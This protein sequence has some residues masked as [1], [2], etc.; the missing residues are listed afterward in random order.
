MET[1]TAQTEFLGIINQ[2]N[3]SDRQ[4][5]KN[6]YRRILKEHNIKPADIVVKIGYMGPNVY[7]WSAKAAPNIPMF[8][9]A[10]AIAVNFGFSIEEFLNYKKEF[11]IN[12]L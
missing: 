10:L 1:I 12:E 11:S 6:N 3:N 7:S 4:I 9:Q 5:I 8:N 2:Y